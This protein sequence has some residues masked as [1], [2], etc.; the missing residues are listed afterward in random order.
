MTVSIVIPC[1]NQ[2]R[3]LA[4]AIDSALEQTH[5]P[6][7]VIVVDDGSTDGTRAVV[8]GRPDVTYIAQ[9]NAGLG[10]ARNTGWRAAGGACVVFLDADDRLLPHALSAGL[11]CLDRYPR[12]VFCAGHYDLV[13]DAGTT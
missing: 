5:P 13:D 10:A 11:A 6:A 3:F 12:A 1:H 4:E 7:E 9:A 2:A 8:A